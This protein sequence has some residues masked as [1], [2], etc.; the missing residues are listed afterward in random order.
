LTLAEKLQGLQNALGATDLRGHEWQYFAKSWEPITFKRKAIITN[1]GQTEKYLYFVVEG[2]QRIYHCSDAGR[3]ATILFTYA[4]SFGGVLDSFLLQ[5]PS[6]FFYE[7]LTKTECLRIPHAPFVDGTQQIPALDALIKQQVY[8]A[9][10]G[11]L[12]RM[13]ELQTFTSEEKLGALMQRSPHILH[14]IP[15]KYLANYL[16]MD[17]TNFSKLINSIRF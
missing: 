7:S 8:Q 1:E 16:G 6:K 11:L 15:Q 10:S 2:V 3:E 13:V 4:P 14:L 5:R 17:A 12:E 9:L